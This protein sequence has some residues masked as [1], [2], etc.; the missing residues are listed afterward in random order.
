MNQLI[1]TTYQHYYTNTHVI[2]CPQMSSNDPI[3]SYGFHKPHHVPHDDV[4]E[5]DLEIAQVAV[6]PKLW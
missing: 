6:C 3:S 1:N 5:A 4:G 2:K